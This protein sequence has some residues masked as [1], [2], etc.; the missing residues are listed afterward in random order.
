MTK[1]DDFYYSE[2]TELDAKVLRLPYKVILTTIQFNFVYVII[3]TIIKSIIVD[4]VG[5]QVQ[6]VHNFTKQSRWIK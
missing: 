4:F 5:L 3:G 6:H 1:T 2:S